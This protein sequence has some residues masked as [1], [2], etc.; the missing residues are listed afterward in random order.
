MEKQDKPLGMVIGKMMKE[1]FS[2]L[3]KRVGEQNE[4]KL[5]ISQFHFMRAISMENDEV[6]QKDMAEIMGK[7]KSA[8]LRMIDCLEKKEL[9]R[10]VVD[11]NDRRKNRL[12]VSKKGERAL[13]QFKIV[14]IELT[15]ELMEGIDIS[16][17]EAFHRVIEHIRNKAKSL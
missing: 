7:D 1:V 3:K 14:E 9:V 2:V 4:V 6:I 17:V 10:R 13:E 16:E 11:L 12:M 8:I 15:N 5:T